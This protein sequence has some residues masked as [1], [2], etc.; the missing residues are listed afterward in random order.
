MKNILGL[1]LLLSLASCET[2]IDFKLV[3]ATPKL[4]V[5]AEIENG[6]APRVLLTKSI[7]YYHVISPQIVLSSFVHNAD[8]YISNGSV[9]HKMKEYTYTLFPGVSASYYGVDSSSLSTA[10]VGE[11]NT[12]YELKII[13]EGEEYTSSTQIPAFN[14]VPDSFYFKQA[15]Q[16]PDT[17]KRVMIIRALDPAGLG[18]YVRYYTK[19]NSESF[20]PGPNSVYTDEIID[21]SAYTIQL[22]QGID[23]YNRPKTGGNFFMKSDTVT[24]KFC[25]IGRSTYQ[26]WNSWEFASQNLGNPFSQPNKI[27]GNISN[28]ALGSFC[29]YAAWYRTLIVK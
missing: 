21:G 19:K 8:V 9:T 22:Q 5:D 6:L 28:G 16:N 7:S 17:N 2:N 4:V 23:R 15:P 18:N 13:S 10:F 1:F 12:N 24:L 25:N 20:F 26:F 27:I 14:V 3:D 29:G 11:P